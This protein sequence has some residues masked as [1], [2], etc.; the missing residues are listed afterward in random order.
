MNIQ[1]LRKLL[2][3]ATPGPWSWEPECRSSKAT[4]YSGRD[5]QHHGLNLF[6]RLEPDSN[7]ANN[8]D[9]IVEAINALPALLDCIEQLEE[10]LAA[11]LAAKR[12][13]TDPRDYTALIPDSQGSWVSY[14]E[15]EA[16]LKG[17]SDV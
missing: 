14:D 12:W 10:R 13:D 3:K 1:Q 2:A 17:D 4:L 7:G 9:L 16:A 6:G 11:A 5:Y 15:L 8:L